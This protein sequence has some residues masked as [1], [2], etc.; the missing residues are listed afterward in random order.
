MA[1]LRPI[2][3]RDSKGNTIRH[4]PTHTYMQAPQERQIMGRHNFEYVPNPEFHPV[5]TAQVQDGKVKFFHGTPDTSGSR[6]AAREISVKQVPAY[7]LAELDKHPMKLRENRPMVQEI[8]VALVGDVEVTETVDLPT[9]GDSIT[10]EP[11]APDLSG[12]RRRAAAPAVDAE[13][14]LG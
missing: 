14:V 9:Q 10:V 4:N 1:T 6:A 13:P 12:R 5:I 2:E 11:V 7:I 8:R 3:D